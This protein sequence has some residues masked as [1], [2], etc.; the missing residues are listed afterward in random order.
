M[1]EQGQLNIQILA[2][3]IR[4]LVQIGTIVQID[5]TKA[6]VR[7]EFAKYFTSDWIDWVEA[8]AST[9]HTWT[10]PKIGGQ[11][12]VLSANGN[13]KRGVVIGYLNQ[14]KYPQISTDGDLQRI[15]FAN[16]SS[17]E[18]HETN[19]T[20]SIH[21]NGSLNIHSTGNMRIS[22]DTDIAIIAPHVGVND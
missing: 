1:S 7:V 6:K 17:V 4:N 20:M 10:P 19:N 5:F 3:Q 9:T 11:A 14:Q 21:C 18:I 16:G 15:K 2:E 13:L 12:I 8:S 22:S